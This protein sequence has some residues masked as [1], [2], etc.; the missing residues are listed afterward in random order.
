[1]P[2]GQ[3]FLPFAVS[4]PPADAATALDEAIALAQE[5]TFAGGEGTSAP[6]IQRAR[7]AIEDI[8]AA[9]VTAGTIRTEIKRSGRQ[10][11]EHP[12]RM[13]DR[14]IPKGSKNERRTSHGDY[15]PT[16]TDYP[17]AAGPGKDAG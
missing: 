15:D 13:R 4:E 6:A 12:G 7:A 9:G 2:E 3:Q 11:S 17:S 1:M 10:R 8:L 5:F 16:R 14:L